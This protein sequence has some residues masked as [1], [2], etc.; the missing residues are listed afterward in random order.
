MVQ[1][2]VERVQA[3]PFYQQIAGTVVLCDVSVALTNSFSEISDLD[4]NCRI[5]YDNTQDPA[6]AE[7]LQELQQNV[8]FLT[9]VGQIEYQLLSMISED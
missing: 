8:Q 1:S 7:Q 3:P 5:L 9:K 6:T 4:L 2:S